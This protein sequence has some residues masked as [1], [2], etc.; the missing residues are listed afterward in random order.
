MSD[1]TL[2]RRKSAKAAI[3]AATLG[4][5]T[6]EV[7]LPLAADALLSALDPGHLTIDTDAYDA[8]SLL[9]RFRDDLLSES[10]GCDAAV[11]AEGRVG[12]TIERA[13]GGVTALRQVRLSHGSSIDEAL[14]AYQSD[15]RVLYAEPNYRVQMIEVPNDPRYSELWGLN[16]EGQTGGTPDVDIDAP[17]AWDVTTGGST[18]VAVIDTGVDYTHPDLAANMWVNPGEIP[19]DGQDN[20]G[21]GF[22]DDV[23]GYDFANN[24]SDPMDDHGH[25]THVAGTIGAVGN[26]G[27]GVAGINWN[28]QLMAVKFLDAS[29]NGTT[30]DAVEAINYAAA[31]GATISNNSWGGYEPFSQAMYDAIAAAGEAG[32][33]FVAGA[34]NGYF[35]LPGG[36]RQSALSI[37]PATTWTTSS[38]WR[39]PTITISRRASPTTDPP[40]STWQL[41]V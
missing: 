9:V 4:F 3:A 27:I 39:R 41:R 12:D 35:W 16:N 6:L 5:E 2:R 11:V 18:L 22:V 29:G 21:N 17:E 31:Q 37:Q 24:D 32:Q 26:N 14:A 40:V 36:H 25:G 30:A 19:N 34:G 7:R 28:V 15:P 33:V 20:D 10:I 23:H 13:L 1:P 8:D 38:P